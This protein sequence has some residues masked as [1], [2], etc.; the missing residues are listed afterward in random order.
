MEHALAHLRFLDIQVL[1]S[2]G[3]VLLGK[4]AR[5]NTGLVYLT[6]KNVGEYVFRDFAQRMRRLVAMFR[7]CSWTRGASRA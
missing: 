5:D 2:S 1:C 6:G 4:L 3:E 7:E